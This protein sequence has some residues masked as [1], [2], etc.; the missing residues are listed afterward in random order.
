MRERGRYVKNRSGRCNIQIIGI[1]G[2]DREN[3]EKETVL[4]NICVFQEKI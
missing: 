4:R 2:V 1:Q 3:N